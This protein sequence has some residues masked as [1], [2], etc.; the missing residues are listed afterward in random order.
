MSYLKIS[1]LTVNI[2]GTSARLLR[3]VSLTVEAGEVHGLV[4]ESG[5]GKSMIGKAVLGTLPRAIEI[6]S[7]A[8]ELDG[9]DLLKLSPAEHRK[10]LGQYRA[11]LHSF[12][13]R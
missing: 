5:A 4:G 3:D 1:N 11:A 10:R 7:G 9:T 13:G 6:I 8:I 2:A 12:A